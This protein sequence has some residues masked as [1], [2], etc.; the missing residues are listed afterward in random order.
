[1]SKDNFDMDMYL[2]NK[3]EVATAFGVLEQADNISEDE[4]TIIRRCL[5]NYN[6]MLDAEKEEGEE[7]ESVNVRLGGVA[8]L[9][10]AWHNLT[11]VVEVLQQLEES[12]EGHT[13][14]ILR[15]LGSMIR[16]FEKEL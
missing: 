3:S 5:S 13:Q 9:W 2:A 8:M 12:S 6:S 10:I 7:L 1:M 14:E 4:K 16:D 15:N 11:D